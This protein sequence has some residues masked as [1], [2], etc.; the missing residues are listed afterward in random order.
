MR[1]NRG[2]ILDEIL[3]VNGLKIGLR[4]G[5]VRDPDWRI[6]WLGSVLL[7]N[8]WVRVQHATGILPSGAVG[9]GEVI[10]QECVIVIQEENILAARGLHPQV[11]A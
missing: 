3:Y 11:S 9:V 1:E 8:P 6:L 2:V 4:H 10:R 5:L 7:D